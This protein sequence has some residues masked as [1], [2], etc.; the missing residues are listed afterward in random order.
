MSF[1]IFIL[2]ILKF[3]AS[4]TNPGK[5][6]KKTTKNIFKNGFKTTSLISTIFLGTTMPWKENGSALK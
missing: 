1:F 6:I 4:P 5:Q 2:M 3:N